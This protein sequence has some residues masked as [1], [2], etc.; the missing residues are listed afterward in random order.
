MN[1]IGLLLYLPDIVKAQ[2]T[3]YPYDALQEDSKLH[4]RF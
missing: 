4:A 2:I 3:E 1:C